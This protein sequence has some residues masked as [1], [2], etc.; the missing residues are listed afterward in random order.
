MERF[1]FLNLNQIS[2]LPKTPGVYCFKGKKEILYI[3]KAVNIKERVKNHLKAPTFRDNLFISK[4][5][6]IGFI[7]TPSE[8]EG[9]ILEA[10]LIKKYQPKFNVLWRDDKN[11]FFV[12]ITLEDFPRV[13]ITHQKKLKIKNEK[14]KINYI[15]PFVDGKALKQALKTL[16]KIFPFRSCKK[17]PKKP[18]LWYQLNRCPAPCLLNSP[19]SLKI[20]KFQS[21]LKDESQKNV[22]NLIKIFQGK[23]SQ[24]LTKLK[25]EMEKAALSQKFE[26]AA[27]IRDQIEAL[28]NIFKHT[29][30]FQQLS[31]KE[32]KNY[33]PEIEKKL[34]T[35]LKMR[36]KIKRIEGYDVSNIQ[37]KQATGSM[38]VFEEGVPKKSEYRKFKIKFQKTPNDIL[39]LKEVLTRRFNHSE[40]EFPQ[41]IFID[42]G[43]AQLNVFLSLKKLKEFQQKLK[44]IKAISL[45]KKR[46]KLFIE[47]RKQPIF[48]KTLFPPLSNLILQIRDEA[49]RFAISYHRKLR[50]KSLF[51]I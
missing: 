36:K 9:L 32:E 30:I 10:K 41:I 29:K 17:I 5:E 34:K 33:W 15:G 13:F 24:V 19:L 22:K 18:C 1:K 35:L 40:W 49:H 42:G 44:E 16:R 23:K 28:E 11:Y 48:L 4:I 43:K 47:G 50:E 2:N 45:A 38:V 20:P 21:S 51:D 6:K 7:Q 3:G 12:G 37:G 31:E 27:K 14:L 8:I 39:M 46:E 25:K 26:K